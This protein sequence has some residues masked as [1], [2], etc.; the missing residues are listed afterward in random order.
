MEN[1]TH[2]GHDDERVISTL[3]VIFVTVEMNYYNYY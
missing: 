1:I 3:N 2:I